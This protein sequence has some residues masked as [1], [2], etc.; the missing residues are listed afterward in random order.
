MPYRQA[1]FDFALI[2]IFTLPLAD[3]WIGCVYLG[4]N[5]QK[6][7]KGPGMAEK[8]LKM[9]PITMLY[10]LLKNDAHRLE[11][12]PAVQWK[13]HRKMSWYWVLNFPVVF[14]LFFFFPKIW[15]GVGLLLNTFYS[16]YANFATDYG[17]IPSSYAA[18]KADEIAARQKH[19]KLPTH[20]KKAVFDETAAEAA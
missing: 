1:D 14:I 9:N 13:F 18:M 2:H 17:A 3:L 19:Q 4:L 20:A 6:L 5:H 16:L 10:H 15:V 7:N 12:D 11:Y 8:L